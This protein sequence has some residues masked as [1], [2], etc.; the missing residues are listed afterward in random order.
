MSGRFVFPFLQTVLQA[1]LKG[2]VMVVAT[3]N[4]FTDGS[5]RV[6]YFMREFLAR[7]EEP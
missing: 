2:G 4:T 5:G 6:P 1:N 3:Y 7:R